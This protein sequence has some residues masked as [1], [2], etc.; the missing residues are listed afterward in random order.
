MAAPEQPMGRNVKP[1]HITNGPGDP[2]PVVITGGSEGTGIESAP[3]TV[4]GIGA[5]VPLTPPPAGTRTM[6]VENTGPGGSFIRVREL[7]GPAGAGVLLPRFGV[8]EFGTTDGSLAALEAEDVS[9]ATGGVAIATTVAVQF[10]KD[11]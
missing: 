3:D 11:A 5:T 9:L 1:V 2:V 6:T 4:V 7:G 10:E 8:R